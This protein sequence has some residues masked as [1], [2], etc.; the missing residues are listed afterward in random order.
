MRNIETMK[1]QAQNFVTEMR[2]LVEKETRSKEDN[3]RIDSLMSQTESL[4]A[5][6]QREERAQEILLSGERHSKQ[7]EVNERAK[8]FEHFGDFVQSVRFNPSDDRLVEIRGQSMGVGSEGGILVPTIFRDQIMEV[9]QQ[10]GIFRPRSTVIPADAS[11][12]DTG[13]TMPVLDQTAATGNMYG[14]VEVSWIGEGVL[15]PETDTKFKD[16]SLK[17]HEVAAHI[18]ATDKLLRNSAAINTTIRRMLS[19]AIMAAEDQAFYNGDGVAKPLGIINATATIATNRTTASKIGYVDVAAM[20]A[21]AKF[22][23]SLVW[24][25]SQSILPELLNM[26]DGSGQLIWQPSAVVGA[27]GTLFGIP[28]IMN[29]RAAQLG[30]KGDLSLVDLSYYLIQNGSPLAISASEHVYFREN[31]TVIK[32]FWNVDGQPWLSGKITQEGGYEVSPFVTL[33]VP[34]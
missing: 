14:G 29:E 27:P 12:P 21:K 17:P 30:S 33:D 23:G 32:A 7:E 1:A 3:E 24:I 25:A 31:K 4:R 16:I 13:I 34:A 2:T 6:I 26:V 11:H 15:K 22:G 28:V 20:Y 5:E 9:G 8:T 10:G 18:V 19:G